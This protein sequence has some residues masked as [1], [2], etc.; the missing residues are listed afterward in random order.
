[1]MFFRPREKSFF[2]NLNNGKT[3]YKKQKYYINHGIYISKRGMPMLKN[4]KECCNLDRI[5]G[6]LRIFRCA[7]QKMHTKGSY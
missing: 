6:E 5:K 3:N 7:N 4:T 2:D 1:M